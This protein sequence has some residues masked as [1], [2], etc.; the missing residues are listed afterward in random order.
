[1]PWGFPTKATW[2]VTSVR[3][4]ASRPDSSGGRSVRN[5]RDFTAGRCAG[6]LALRKTFTLFLLAAFHHAGAIRVDLHI[7]PGVFDVLLS[8]DIALVNGF[9]PRRVHGWRSGVGRVDQR[10]RAKQDG[11]GESGS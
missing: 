11:E 4:S 3:C 10:W 2:R 9:L 6:S 5:D 1:M 8:P 7:A